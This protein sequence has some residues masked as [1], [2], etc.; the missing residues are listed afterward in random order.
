[1]ATPPDFT[2]GQILTSAAMN[3]VGMWKIAPTVSG[4][5]V[6]I[7]A[8]KNIILTAATAAV[9]TDA[10]PADFYNFVVYLSDFS[11]TSSSNLQLQL[12][13]TVA[14]ATNYRSGG[15]FS[16]YAGSFGDVASITTHFGV[17]SVTSAS[18]KTSA[19]CTIFNPNLAVITGYKS[20]VSNR[21]AW[22]ANGGQNTNTTAYTN[23][24]LSVSAGNCT[25]KISIYGLR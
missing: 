25:G 8:D 14:I 5:G 19:V 2:A 22:F 15:R 23:L 3:A 21:D 10:F 17:G 24:S 4:S 20:E 9:M 16:T 12:Y 7:D 1:M 6:T 13:T 11:G 18:D